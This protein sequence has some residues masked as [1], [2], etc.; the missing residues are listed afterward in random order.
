MYVHNTFLLDEGPALETLDCFLYWQYT[1]CL[2]FVLYD[3]YS[4][5]TV[6]RALDRKQIHA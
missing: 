6:P 1:K 2:Y 4:I 3:I 5:S